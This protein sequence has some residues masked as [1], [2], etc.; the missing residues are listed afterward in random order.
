MPSKGCPDVMGDHGDED[1]IKLFFS[2]HFLHLS[3]AVRA[4]NCALRYT[5]KTLGKF[6]FCFERLLDQALEKVFLV[7]EAFI[8]DGEIDFHIDH[9]FPDICVVLE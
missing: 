5:A 4:V 8:F 1:K 2:Q 7:F 6:Q 9:N 3:I